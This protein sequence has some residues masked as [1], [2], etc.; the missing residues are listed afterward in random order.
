MVSSIT[1]DPYSIPK[2][3]IFTTFKEFQ[4]R[5]PPASDRATRGR[6]NIASRGEPPSKP[7]TS[8]TA[9]TAM[10]H[11]SSRGDPQLPQPPH[12][13]PPSPSGGE[14]EHC[15]QGGF[16]FNCATQTE[17]RT[18]EV[19][20][21]LI[22]SRTAGLNTHEH[23]PA[24]SMDGGS[25][26]R[27]PV[28]AQP[29]DIRASTEVQ[30][31]AS[32]RQRR[33]RHGSARPTPQHARRKEQTQARPKVASG[34]LVRD[35][36]TCNRLWTSHSALPTDTMRVMPSTSS[37]Q[38]HQAGT[39]SDAPRSPNNESAFLP[40]RFAEGRPRLHLGEIIGSTAS[41]TSRVTSSTPPA[42]CEP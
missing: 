39:Y 17:T 25:R 36:D 15:T 21:V 6:A 5:P 1:L 30:A 40:E 37:L 7:V 23:T 22:V 20:P 4:K 31:A 9:R 11:A 33:I 34:V 2:S 12:L 10:S 27:Q 24:H 14:G 18:A 16:H 32:M 38:A 8:V 26:A 19:R 42:S 41:R 28:D 13:P 35:A 3:L 29:T